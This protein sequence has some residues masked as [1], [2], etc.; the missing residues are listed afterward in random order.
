MRLKLYICLLTLVVQAL[1]AK[2]PNIL[3]IFADDHAYDAVGAHGNSVIKTPNLDRLSERGTHFSH[4]YNSGAWGGAVCVASRT[5]LQTGRQVWNARKASL[6]EL[7]ERGE[8]FPQQ[9]RSAGYETY[10]AGKWH[11][12]KTKLAAAAWKHVRNVRPG[13]PKQVKE[14][15]QRNFTPG[16]DS[17]DPVDTAN[18]G[19]WAGGKHW[20][21]VLA[22][23][24][25]EFIQQAADQ[26]KPFMMMLCF[27]A[28]HDPRQ[29]PQAYQEMYP[30]DSIPLPQNFL[31]E[32]P[33]EIGS[34]QVRD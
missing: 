24:G 18:G 28:P 4:A 3:F 33:Y 16:Q 15:Y 13:M 22:D 11:V 5:M 6:D 20:S 12:G 10:F 25:I 17:W 7:L 9:M 26:D 27:N 14:R 34:N 30:Y 31:T 23:D 19:F 8:F 2:Q 29:A 21:E 1:S 32:Y